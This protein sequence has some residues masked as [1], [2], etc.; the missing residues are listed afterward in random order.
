MTELSNFGIV[1]PKNINEVPKEVFVRKDLFEVEQERI[2]RGPEWHPVAHVGELPNPGDFKTYPLGTVPLLITHGKDGEYRVF[3]NACSH[4]S[5]QLETAAFGN[6]T[7]FE[8]P[9]HRWLFNPQGE[10]IG[11]PN[12]KEF[13]PGFKREDYPLAQPRMEMFC[14]LIF[15][16]MRA[17][18]PPLDEWL[19]EVKSTFRQAMGGDGRLKL[20][21]Y[22]KVS[23]KTNW[24]GYNDNDGYHAPLLHTAFTLLNWQGGQGRQYSDLVRGHLGFEADLSP[25]PKSDMIKDHSLVEY[26]GDPANMGSRLIQLFP[27]MVITRHLNIFNIRFAIARGPED[28]EVHY[29]YFCHEDD[30]EEM[31]KHRVRQASNLLGPCGM[32]SMEDASI[33]H[34]IHIGSGTPGNAIFQKGVKSFDTLPRDIKQND[35]TGNLAR[36][37]YYRKV[38]GFQRALS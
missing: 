5:N 9:Y 16:T 18:T 7:E 34:R 21:G 20:L 3:Y 27:T 23:Y 35:E 32:I 25:V 6:K 17:E 26:K 12:S 36:W 37:E 33:F 30:D 13:S 15:V 2:F 14:G 22:Q 1:W 29:A 28:T 19:G 24:K 31:I 38:M 4:R 8:C 10:L 11:C